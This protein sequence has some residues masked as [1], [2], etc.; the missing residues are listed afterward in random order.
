ML[1]ETVALTAFSKVT[2]GYKVN[3]TVSKTIGYFW[4][5]IFRFWALPKHEYAQILCAPWDNYKISI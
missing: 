4:V 1:L 3:N 5:F 2:K